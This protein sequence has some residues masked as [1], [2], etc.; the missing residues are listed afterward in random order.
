MQPLAAP[1]AQEPH[2]D[3]PR[4]ANPD[5]DEQMGEVNVIFEGSMS[6]TSKT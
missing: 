1:V 3:E 6:T 5:D 2:W 4:Q